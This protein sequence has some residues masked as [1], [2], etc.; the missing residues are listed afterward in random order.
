MSN[1]NALKRMETI[2]NVQMI[3]I[4]VQKTLKG[5]SY[6]FCKKRRKTNNLLV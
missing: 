2:K 4:S 1:K 3:K 6:F 5:L